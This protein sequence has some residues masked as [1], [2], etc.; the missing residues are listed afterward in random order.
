MQLKKRLL[1]IGHTIAELGLAQNHRGN[2]LTVLSR[3]S[4]NDL[5]GQNDMT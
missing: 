4:V 5:P 3:M 2:Q 1:R